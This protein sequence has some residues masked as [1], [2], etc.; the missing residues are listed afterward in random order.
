[1]QLEALR[2]TSQNLN[3]KKL[4]EECFHMVGRCATVANCASSLIYFIYFFAVQMTSFFV[5]CVSNRVQ[6]SSQESKE[7]SNDQR[8]SLILNYTWPICFWCQ[9]A[10]EPVMTAYKLVTVDVPYWGFGYRLEQA[11]LGVCHNFNSHAL[12]FDQNHPVTQHD[13]GQELVAYY[14]LHVRQAFGACLEVV[15]RF[16]RRTSRMGFIEGILLWH[17]KRC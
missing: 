15:W 5:Y 7:C 10:S 13:I 11:L 17:A 1:M 16:E 4:E 8:S 2:L 6:G 9:A 12:Q 14:T 3:L